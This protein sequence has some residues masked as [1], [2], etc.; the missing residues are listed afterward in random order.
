MPRERKSE[1][2]PHF[3]DLLKRRGFK[4]VS[5]LAKRVEGLPITTFYS[6]SSADNGHSQL[7]AYLKIAKEMNLPLE[8]WAK[9]ILNQLDENEEKLLDDI[10]N[11]A[12][13]RLDAYNAQ[14]VTR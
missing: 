14:S 5:A 10:L 6:V 9:K 11:G 4:D 13:W 3:N 7:R 12:E 2:N 1:A 8:L